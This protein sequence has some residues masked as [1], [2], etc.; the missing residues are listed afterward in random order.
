MLTI[1]QLCLTVCY[2]VCVPV[3]MSE[4]VKHGLRDEE[5]EGT[6]SK[7]MVISVEEVMESGHFY[8]LQDLPPESLEPLNVLIL[9]PFSLTCFSEECV[10]ER[11]CVKRADAGFFFFFFLILQDRTAS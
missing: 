4:V 6:C 3:C 10:L 11:G 1:S 8:G 2:C 9:F 7:C 5:K